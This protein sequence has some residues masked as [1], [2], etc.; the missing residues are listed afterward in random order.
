MTTVPA[1]RASHAM[2]RFRSVSHSPCHFS[3]EMRGMVQPERQAEASGK[4]TVFFEQ[5]KRDGMPKARKASPDFLATHRAYR[6]KSA[7]TRVLFCTIAHFVKKRTP[8]G[9]SGRSAFRLP[10]SPAQARSGPP[11]QAKAARP[12][13]PL[14]ARSLVA[15]PRKPPLRAARLQCEAGAG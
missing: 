12:R 3:Y 2:L 5:A 13:R 10:H 1:N 11:A 14:V 7:G 4:R 15:R 9:F 8:C 6:E